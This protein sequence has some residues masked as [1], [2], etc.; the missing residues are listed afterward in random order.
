M[1][2][3]I[4][5]ETALPEE[6]RSSDDPG[7]T[8]NMSGLADQEAEKRSHSVRTGT[9]LSRHEGASLSLAP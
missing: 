9:G 5:W 4:W 8:P 1:R 7:V 2:T 6:F 3:G